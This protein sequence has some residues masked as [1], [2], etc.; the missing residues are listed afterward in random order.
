MKNA[1]YLLAV[2]ADNTLHRAYYGNSSNEK[3]MGIRINGVIT[4]FRSINLLLRRN[5]Y[6]HLFTAWD[7]KSSLLQRASVLAPYNIIYK[8]RESGLTEEQLVRRAEIHQQKIICHKLLVAMGIPSVFSDSKVNGV[9]ADDI[10]ATVAKKV[11]L[12]KVDILSSDKDLAQLISG[13]I[14]IY[15]PHKKVIVDEFDCEDHYGVP[16]EQVVDYLCLVGDDADN[17][18][19]IKGCGPKTALKLLDT[20]GSLEDIV[21]NMKHI[22]GAVGNVL[23]SGDH[24]PI[25]VLR[26][27]ITVNTEVYKKGDPRLNPDTMNLELIREHIQNNRDVIEGLKQSVGLEGDLMPELGI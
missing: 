23:R 1:K 5:Y 10:L 19:G 8:D 26:E 20:Y 2:D 6:D 7:I 25:E 16:P 22:K 21:S 11:K 14:S 4:F 24:L 13:K 3:P 9:E 18:P 17:I 12:K 27:V 15:N